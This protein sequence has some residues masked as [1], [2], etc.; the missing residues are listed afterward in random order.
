M[1]RPL[2][3][4][5]VPG[6]RQ[7]IEHGVNGLLCAVRSPESLADAMRDIGMMN[8]DK[9]AE[10]G[11]A[12]RALVERSYGVDKVIA[13]YLEAMAQLAPAVGV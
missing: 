6:N 1:A 9:R 5:N 10:M 13:A 7:L 2:I 11:L 8:A 3:A 12:G 4:S